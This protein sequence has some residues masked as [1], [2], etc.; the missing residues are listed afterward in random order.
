MMLI[1]SG[2]WIANLWD[3]METY[4]VDMEDTNPLSQNGALVPMEDVSKQ[5]A[6]ES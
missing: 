6:Y 1:R 2:V 4:R 3:S 5:R